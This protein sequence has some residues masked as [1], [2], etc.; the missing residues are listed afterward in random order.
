MSFLLFSDLAWSKRTEEDS[1][2]NMW[3]RKYSKKSKL[4]AQQITGIEEAGIFV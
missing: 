2:N 1:C 3:K 4:F